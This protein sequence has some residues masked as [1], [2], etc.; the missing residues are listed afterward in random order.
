MRLR[1]L[2]K[3]LVG[4]IS[5][6]EAQLRRGRPAH[7]LQPAAGG[8]LGGIQLPGLMPHVQWFMRLN[9]DVRLD[10]NSTM[11]SSG[12]GGD[13]AVRLVPCADGSLVAGGELAA[14]LGNWRDRAVAGQEV[15]AA[16]AS[17]P[18]STT[19]ASSPGL[20]AADNWEFSTAR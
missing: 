11:V 6:A 1:Y 16:S 4:E 15:I 5:K 18:L 2:R 19:T 12:A 7:A 8:V 14:L 10:S 20:K 13:V 17:R 9:P 3:R